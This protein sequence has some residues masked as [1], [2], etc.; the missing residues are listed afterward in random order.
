MKSWSRRKGSYRQR[1]LKGILSRTVDPV[2]SCR[3]MAAF[4]VIF[5]KKRKEAGGG[6]ECPAIRWL[7]NAMYN[8]N[9]LKKSRVE[10]IFFFFKRLNMSCSE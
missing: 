1:C 9:G 4:E 2:F 10:V 5:A 6:E 8:I 3:L 7:I